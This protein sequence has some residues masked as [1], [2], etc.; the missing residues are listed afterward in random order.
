V[1]WSGLVCRT[2]ESSACITGR[3]VFGRLKFETGVHRVQRVPETETQGRT[4]TST[5]TV[6]VL[7]VA[8]EVR[9]AQPPGHLVPLL[10]HGTRDT[11]GLLLCV[12]VC[13]S[14]V[15]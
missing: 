12:C 8:Q 9:Y 13:V 15:F 6:A 3:G 14:C 2:Q 5:V 10:S 11:R 7:P 4:H 1:A